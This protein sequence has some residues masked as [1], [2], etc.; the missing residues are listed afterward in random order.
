MRIELTTRATVRGLFLLVCLAFLCPSTWAASPDSTCTP[1]FYLQHDKP[2]GWLGADAAYSIPLP[3]GRDLWIFGDTLYGETRAVH[4][5]APQM[6]RNS[7]GIS[8]CEAG[9]WKLTYT[10]RKDATGQPQSFFTPRL[11][12]TWYWALDG[13]VAGRNVWVTLLCVRNAPSKQSQAMAFETCGSDL[14]RITA[15]GP[16]PQQWKIDTFP[17]VPDGVR[18]Y[19]SATTVV[20]GRDAYLFAQFESGTRPLLATRIPLRELGDPAKHLEYLATNGEWKRGLVPQ[21]AAQVMKQGSSELSIRYHPE[22][23]KWLA[24]MF[25]PGAFSSHIVLR[26][27]PALTG[28][29]TEGQTI[30]QVPEMQ[31]SKPGYDKDTFCYAAKEHPE[32]ERGD[33]VFTYVCNTYAVPK[34]AT[35]LSI[36]FPQVVRMPMPKL[37]Q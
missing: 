8:T 36:Y 10:I 26:S 27:A 1:K 11:P 32:F 3:D 19:P 14:A 24:V 21:D 4:G 30:Y 37:A 6:V 5:D 13:F 2:L 33:L 22:L 17:L 31:P 15:P 18:A 35:N 9:Q 16:D 20:E 28:P 25:A 23:H 7:I 34:L 29:W 12:H